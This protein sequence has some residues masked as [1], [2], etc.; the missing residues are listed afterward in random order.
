M[1]EPRGVLVIKETDKTPFYKYV[2]N[3]LQETISVKVLGI[4][5][6]Q[7]FF[8]RGR[9]EYLDICKKI[10]FSAQAHKVDKGYLYPH[11]VYVAEK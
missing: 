10:G 7:Q 4:T 5:K 11:I 2:F 3:Y 8:F 1:L 6:G 9:N